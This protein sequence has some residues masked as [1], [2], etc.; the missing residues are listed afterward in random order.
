MLHELLERLVKLLLRQLAALPGLL[1]RG[2]EEIVPAAFIGHIVQGTLKGIRE[3]GRVLIANNLVVIREV[4]SVPIRVALAV[5]SRCYLVN[6]NAVRG[7]Q[8]ELRRLCTSGFPSVL[9]R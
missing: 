6:S 8:R 5:G 3:V 4:A 7:V 9:P 2:G 1:L